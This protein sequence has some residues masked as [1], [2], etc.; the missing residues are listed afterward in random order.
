MTSRMARKFV[1]LVAIASVSS[2]V[3]LGARAG[4]CTGHIQV[5]SYNSNAAL[6]SI[7]PNNVACTNKNTDGKVDGRIILPGSDQISFRYNQDIKYH[8]SFVNAVLNGLGF[9]NKKVPL[10]RTDSSLTGDSGTSYWY[11]TGEVTIDPSRSGCLKIK[12]VYQKVINRKIV[13]IV[14]ESSAWHTADSKC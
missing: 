14:N 6:V 11:A 5:F 1:V 13:T 10:A 4:T 8:P 2:L 7:D 3:Q 9:V 12:F